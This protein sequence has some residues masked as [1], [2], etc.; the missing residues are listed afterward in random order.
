VRIGVFV[1]KLKETPPATSPIFTEPE[2]RY[3]L[4]RRNPGPHFAGRYA[5]KRAACIA[6]GV[7]EEDAQRLVSDVEVV[8][9]PGQ[10]PTLHLVGAAKRLGE[11]GERSHVSISHSGNYAVALVVIE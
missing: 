3:C 6:L 2:R 7:G 1:A 11:P 10:A 8:R 4:A 9:E 5:A